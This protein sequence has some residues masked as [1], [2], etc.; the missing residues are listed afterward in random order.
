MKL[1]FDPTQ[2]KWKKNENANP[3]SISGG[4]WKRTEFTA[5]I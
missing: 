5:L 3:V 4:S 2:K 1:F